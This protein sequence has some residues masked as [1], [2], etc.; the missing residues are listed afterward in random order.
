MQ[1]QM[2]NVKGMLCGGGHPVRL[3]HRWHPRD[4]R[5]RSRPGPLRLT[6]PAP[7]GDPVPS[8]IYE[9][10][11]AYWLATHS[12]RLYVQIGDDY[13]DYAAAYLYGVF[14]YHAN[15]DRLFDASEADPSNGWES[16]IWRSARGW[17][18]PSYCQ[19]LPWHRRPAIIDRPGAR[20]RQCH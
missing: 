17:N 6:R 12:T 9:A 4:Q 20:D 15:P 13:D 18:A 5:P 8:S 1:T 10:Q 14:L 2:M 7:G 3:R 16:A 19:R 11:Y